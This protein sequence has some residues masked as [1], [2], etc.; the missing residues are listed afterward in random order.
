MQKKINK[1][2][3]FLRNSYFRPPT[4]FT[5]VE[6][7]VVIGIISL[8]IGTVSSLLLSGISSQSRIL[9]E[10]EVS[11]QVSYLLEYMGRALRMA[12]KDDLGGVNCLS[13]DKVNY[14]INPEKNAIKFRNYRDECQRFFLDGNQIKE[15]RTGIVLPLTSPALKINSLKFDLSGESQADKIQPKITIF[16]EIEGRGRNPP[17]IQIQTTIS[18]RN[19]DVKY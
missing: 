18:Q 16:L 17:K 6:L 5:L 13:G 12:K 14:E 11:D 1:T 2:S 9:A 4:G 15:E 19:L 8:T 10:Q 3:S 7:L